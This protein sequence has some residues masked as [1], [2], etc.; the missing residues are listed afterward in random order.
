MLGQVTYLPDLSTFSS[1]MDFFPAYS[2][3]LFWDAN[4]MECGFPFACLFSKHYFLSM[5]DYVLG[6]G[7]DTVST[8]KEL[9]F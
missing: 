8:L 6:T 4:D 5:L 3:G 7:Y 1:G 2:T 9:T